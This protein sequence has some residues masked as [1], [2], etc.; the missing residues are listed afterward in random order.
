LTRYLAG[1]LAL[2]RRELAA[3]VLLFG[4]TLPAVTPRIY[5]SDEIQYVSYLRSLWF[6]RDVSFENEY[7]YFYERN[8]GRGEHFYET[9]LELQ[10]EAGRR[11]NFATLG[12]AILWAPFYAVGH[13]TALCLRSMGQEVPADGFSKPY[14]AAIAYGSAC[15]GF[16]AVLLSIAAAR[17]ITSPAFADLSAGA[18]AQAEASARKSRPDI[19]A[20]I[21]VWFGTPLLFYMYVAP[22][23]AHAC[24]AFAVALFVSIWLHVRR[25]W[26][27]SGALALG[28]SGALMA[29]VR[30]QDAFFAIGPALDL[31]LTAVK[32]QRAQLWQV[33]AAGCVAFIGGLSPQLLAYS[34]L[35]GRPGPSTL[36]MRKMSWH[37]PHA[38][39]VLTSSAHGFL[40]WTPVAILAIGGLMAL[41]F[42][43]AGDTRRIGAMALLMTAAQVYVSGSVDSWT[44]AGA[45][46]QRRFVALTIL[47]AIGLAVLLR[48]LPRGP[49]RVAAA[50]ALIGCVWWNLALTALFGTGLM[51]RQRLQIQRNAYDVFVTIPRMAPD[52]ARRY[53][54]TRDS[55]YQRRDEAR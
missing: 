51:N 37:S 53:F 48:A 42:R 24:S 49:W 40:A 18:F 10:T 41:A 14:I 23:F 25:N 9:F 5:A 47:L 35:N 46:G 8:I 31:I 28:L 19:G 30:E 54:T 3:L 29:M 6:D 13:L 11:P 4:V 43:G 32:Q 52:L 1:L 7:R 12:A 21:A 44:V 33:A 39:D 17:R 38:F 50:V 20:G 27:V 2:S 55:F 15:Y 36:V 16:L 22:P 45:F 26:S 34:A